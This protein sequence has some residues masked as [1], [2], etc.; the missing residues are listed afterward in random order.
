MR[1]S[2]HILV[3]EDN[4]GDFILVKHFLEES[5]T[6]AVV[7]HSETL[8]EA[9]SI[10]AERQMDAI[11][12]DLSLP[13]S[14]GIQSVTEVVNAAGSIPVIVLTGYGNRDFGVETLAAGVEDYLVKDE[15]NAT[16]LAK[17]V[18]Y[19]IERSRIRG[20]LKKQQALFQALTEKSTD[21]KTLV[22]PEGKIVYGTP[23]I[24]TYLGHT[25]KEFMQKLHSTFI[26]PDDV[27]IFKVAALEAIK[28]PALSP[29][30]LLRMLHADGSY[31]WCEKNITNMLDDPNVSA[32][33]CN[34]RDVT[35]RMQHV[36]EI[37]KQNILL[38]EIAWIQSHEVRAP[39]ARIMGL[40]SLLKR[41]EYELD[42]S[43]GD[44]LDHIM[45]SAHDL[46]AIIKKIVDKTHELK[47]IK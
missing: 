24:T 20:E 8:S 40:I 10:I 34:F 39:I 33:V 14:S 12:L 30:F 25:E 38:K 32:L 37:E 7:H 21:M 15:I 5:Y 28:Q 44:M 13:D 19:S 42:S 4:E 41:D 3:V 47:E 43:T 9:I 18:K 17:S 6:N 45:G 11:L 2:L 35:E 16:S 22:T 36:Q 26:H 29:S 27:E 46:D 1:R 23:S 31:R